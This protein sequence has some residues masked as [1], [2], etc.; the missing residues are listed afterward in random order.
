[1]PKEKCHCKENWKGEWQK[2]KPSWNAKTGMI[3][4]VFLVEK[5]HIWRDRWTPEEA[6][7]LVLGLHDPKNKMLVEDE[8]KNEKGKPKYFFCNHGECRLSFQKHRLNLHRHHGGCVGGDQKSY[9][10][11]I[12]VDHVGLDTWLDMLKKAKTRAQ[13]IDVFELLSIPEGRRKSRKREGVESSTKRRTSKRGPTPRVRKPPVKTKPKNVSEDD[14]DDSD[15]RDKEDDHSGDEEDSE[16]KEDDKGFR[17]H[18]KGLRLT[19]RDDEGDADLEN[20]GNID[21]GASASLEIDVYDKED[22]FP[23]IDDTLQLVVHDLTGTPVL[24]DDARPRSRRHKKG[25]ALET[26]II[27]YH[28][29]VEAE[30]PSGSRHLIPRSRTEEL[31]L[32]RE[33]EVGRIW[34]DV[35]ATYQMVVEQNPVLRLQKTPL[36]VLLEGGLVPEEFL[37]TIDSLPNLTAAVSNIVGNGEN[38]ERFWIALGK[39]VG[40]KDISIELFDSMRP[41]M[42]EISGVLAKQKVDGNQDWERHILATWKYMERNQEAD[43]HELDMARRRQENEAL[44]HAEFNKRVDAYNQFMAEEMEAATWDF[45][46]LFHF[47]ARNKI[48]RELLPRMPWKHDKDEAI[49][50]V[51]ALKEAAIPAVAPPPEVRL[52]KCWFVCNGFNRRYATYRY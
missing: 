14:E 24:E 16:A 52:L 19:I 45:N 4:Q 2:T 48:I 23:G 3:E 50:V 47:C 46:L 22:H 49:R 15:T 29:D 26:R 10:N 36:Y 21:Q 1:M 31:Q 42:M 28:D 40:N 43:R 34:E 41:F 8:S 38:S 12:G 18:D 17:V 9:P 25:A 30:D 11:L 51:Q 33:E 35:H 5:S 27:T 20:V 7:L 13:I 44:L 37:R 6:R 39:T 32:R